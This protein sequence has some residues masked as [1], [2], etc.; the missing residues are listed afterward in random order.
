MYFF[1]FD[2]L[3]L[4][5]ELPC[6]RGVS[7]ASQ[8]EWLVSQLVEVLLETVCNFTW[9]PY[10]ASS[11]RNTGSLPQHQAAH[12]IGEG[13]NFELSVVSHQSSNYLIRLTLSCESAF[14]CV[15]FRPISH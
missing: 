14:F 6:G 2:T 10:Q 8:V 5:I 1:H 7:T 12:G 3:C 15:C 13:E 11:L 9:S 4:T